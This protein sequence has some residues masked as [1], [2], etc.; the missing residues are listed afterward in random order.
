MDNPQVF[1][2]VILIRLMIPFG[3]LLLIG[4]WNRHR[5]GYDR[6]RNEHRTDSILQSSVSLQQALENS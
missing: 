3:I 2:T 6:F 4:E 5:E 1:L